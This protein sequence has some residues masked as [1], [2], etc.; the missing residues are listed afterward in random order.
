MTSAE[1][2]P[3]PAILHKSS[4]AI[5][6]LSLIFMIISPCRQ[7]ADCGTESYMSG[8]KKLTDGRRMNDYI[9]A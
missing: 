4:L 2:P 5:P 3:E 7:V 8:G 9:D 6:R 1:L